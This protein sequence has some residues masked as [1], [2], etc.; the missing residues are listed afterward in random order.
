L[1][2]T[3]IALLSLLYLSRLVSDVAIQVSQSCVDFDKDSPPTTYGSI[4]DATRLGNP[5]KDYRVSFLWKHAPVKS[6]W[7]LTQEPNTRPVFNGSLIVSE[8]SAR[9]H[10]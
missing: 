9:T 4:A 1:F 3:K 2:E 8:K 5:A 10:F 7:L 6:T